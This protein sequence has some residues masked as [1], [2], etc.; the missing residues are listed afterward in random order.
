[1]QKNIAQI[2]VHKRRPIIFI[3][4]ENFFNINLTFAVITIERIDFS[5]KLRLVYCKGSVKKIL[6][7]GWLQSRLKDDNDLRIFVQTHSS[8]V[9][10]VFR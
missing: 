8:H 2:R 10:R 6:L 7:T 4:L 1:M 5:S 3:L 9:H